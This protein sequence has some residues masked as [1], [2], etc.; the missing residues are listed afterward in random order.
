[1]SNDTASPEILEA[2][3]G[4]S[5]LLSRMHREIGLAAVAIALELLEEDLGEDLEDAIERGAR[6]LSR[7][8][9]AV[10]S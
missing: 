5:R 9:Y 3:A 8:P 6:F 10:A 1:M 7:F 4:R 2:P